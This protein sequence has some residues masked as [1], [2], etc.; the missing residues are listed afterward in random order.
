MDSALA[1][2]DKGRTDVN[3]AEVMH[4]IGDVRGRTCLVLDDLIDT[5]G[6]LG[7]TP[8]ALLENGAAAV[9]FCASPAVRSGRAGC[10]IVHPP[11]LEMGVSNTLPLHK[12]PPQHTRQ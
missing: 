2:V 9:F 11:L 3:V 1:I 5:A 12:P 7:K 8:H 10:A 4:V 6:T